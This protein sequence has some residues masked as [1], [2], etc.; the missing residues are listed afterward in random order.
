MHTTI[1]ARVG[2]SEYCCRRR[3]VAPRKVGMNR[4][5]KRNRPCGRF[6]APTVSLVE[7]AG[8]LFPVGRIG[9]RRAPAG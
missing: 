7:R 8:R 4:V 2:V 6:V 5:Q 9:L 3:V 1:S